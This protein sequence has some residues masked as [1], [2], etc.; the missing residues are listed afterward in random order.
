MVDFKVV[1]NGNYLCGESPIW[2][3]RDNK[4][5]WCDLLPKTGLQDKPTD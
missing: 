5:Y 1:V 3:T 2:D 4:F